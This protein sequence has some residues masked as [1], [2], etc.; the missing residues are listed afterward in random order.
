ML[1]VKVEGSTLGH[2]PEMMILSSKSLIGSV[3]PSTAT[4]VTPVNKGIV[5][6]LRRLYGGAEC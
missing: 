6:L 1:T 5:C 4:T 3:V 2:R